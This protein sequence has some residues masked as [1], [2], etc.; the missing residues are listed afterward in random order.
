MNRQ[1]AAGKPF[2]L[3]LPFSMGH[4]PNLQSKQFAGKSR[5]GQYGD[6]LIEGDYHVGQILD[7]LKELGID[8]NTLGV[9]SSDNEQQGKATRELGNQGSP[10]TGKSGPVEWHCG[11][12]T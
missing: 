2:F 4:F 1:K 11:E 10:D 5:I 3:Y 9:F 6:K 8:D 7:T 12:V